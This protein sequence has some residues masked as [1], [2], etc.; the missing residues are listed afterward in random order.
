MQ[1]RIASQINFPQ[2]PVYLLAVTL[3]FHVAGFAI[4]AQVSRLKVDKDL[5]SVSPQHTGNRISSCKGQK[6]MEVS[7]RELEADIAKFRR[8][9]S[10]LGRMFYCR[11]AFPILKKHA[12]DP[13]PKLREAIAYYLRLYYSSETL[14]LLIQQ[15]ERYPSEKSAVPYA[16]TAEHPCYFFKRVRSRSLTQA[17]TARIKARDDNENSNEIRLLGCLSPKDLQARKFLEEMSRPSFATRLSESDRQDQLNLVTYAL[18]E[19]GVK[20]AEAKI[21]TD[22][23]AATAT[24]NPAAIQSVLEKVKGFT[25][26]RILRSLARLILDKRAVSLDVSQAGKIKQLQ[27]RVGDIA[28]SSFTGALGTQIT[29]E[30]DVEWK[31]HTDAEMERIYRRVNGAL[32]SG[33]FSTCHLQNNRSSRSLKS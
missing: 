23:E 15:I 18:A 28:I 32:K 30:P 26:C 2:L 8:G 14:Q 9:E 6:G 11:E 17:L 3:A 5:R 19:A 1:Y 13:D 12:L 31:P 10:S 29:G 24:G 20:E 27:A 7:R 22:I 4:S 21:S 25:N 33:K 16:Y